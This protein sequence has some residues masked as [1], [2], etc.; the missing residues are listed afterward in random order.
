MRG[1][2]E[3]RTITYETVLTAV[4][5]HKRASLS[6][7]QRHL[8]LGYNEAVIMLERMELEGLIGPADGRKPRVLYCLDDVEKALCLNYDKKTQRCKCSEGK[9]PQRRKNKICF[10]DGMIPIL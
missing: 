9:C 1:I 3:V 8:G 6:F 4:K 7:F 10:S 2:R 5:R